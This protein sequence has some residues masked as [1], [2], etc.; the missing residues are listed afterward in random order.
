MERIT[1]VQRQHHYVA[2]DVAIVHF[3]K[4]RE[5]YILLT[6]FIGGGAPILLTERTSTAIN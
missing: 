4:L 5:S 1:Q 3:I 6:T 2:K